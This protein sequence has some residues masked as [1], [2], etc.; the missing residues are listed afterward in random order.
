MASIGLSKFITAEYHE[1]E[2][3][4]YYSAPVIGPKMVSA[5]VSI[6]GR[7]P[8]ILRADNRPAESLGIFGSGT[9]SV[10]ID[11]LGF[12]DAYHLLGARYVSGANPARVVFSTDDNPVTHGVAFI[13]K[14]IV[15][16]VV[17][18]RLIA[19]KRCK[20]MV[21]NYTLNTQA[22]T[23][24]F[25]VPKLDATILR[26]YSGGWQAWGDYDTEANALGAVSAIFPTSIPLPPTP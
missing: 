15:H 9:L 6:D 13:S 22:Q 3:G 8:T 16:G 26:D 7:E 17:R 4:N 21:P 1:N 24:E 5:D 2:Y 23:I 14:N 19:F 18:W 20:F 25:Q 11:E 10:E 12:Y